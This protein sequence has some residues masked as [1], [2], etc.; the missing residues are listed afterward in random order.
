[1]SASLATNLL[2]FAENNATSRPQ[3]VGAGDGY[4]RAQR[5]MHGHDY[6]GMS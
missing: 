6:L 5:L 1:M 4:S 3:V 2:I